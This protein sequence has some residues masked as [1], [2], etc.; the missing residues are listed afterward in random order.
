MGYIWYFIGIT[1]MAYSY[2]VGSDTT[3]YCPAPGGGM[4]PC[5]LLDYEEES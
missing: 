4:V 1:V 5:E 2:V 3:E